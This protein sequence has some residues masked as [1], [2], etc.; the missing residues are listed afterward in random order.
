MRKP[1]VAG[2]FYAGAASGL[3]RQI[4]DCFK[5]TLGPGALPRAPKAGERHI[6]GLVSPHAGYIYSGPVAAHGF[7]QLALE[8]KPEVVV[9]LGPN[10]RGIGAEVA[11]SKEDRWQTPL[12]YLEIDS[13]V[14]ERIVS[15]A[16]WAQWDDLAHSWEHSIEV[17]L[18][19]LQYIYQAGIRV[20][21][22]AMLRQDLEASQDLGGAIATALKGRNGIIVA[23]SDFTHYESQS[24]A[25]K[26]DNLA[27][28][29]IL[30]LDAKQ[31]ENV[32]SRHNISMCGPGPVMSMLTACQKLAASQARLLRYA[33]SGDITGDYSQVV[34]YASVEVTR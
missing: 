8:G 4:E 14:G 9:I 2:S 29:A 3:H 5:H 7:F 26:K 22:I 33:T 30:S 13:E 21:P 19:F 6:L 1:V 32:V 25:S 17:Q 18:P 27:L 34:G 31:L 11:L 24:A 12:G 16:R 28:E 23:S 10:H 15:A 20:V